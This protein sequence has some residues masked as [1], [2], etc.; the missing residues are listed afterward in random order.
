MPSASTS[1]ATVAL[2]HGSSVGEAV[3]VAVGDTVG[4]EVGK[5]VGGSVGLAV[6]VAVGVAVGGTVGLEVGNAVGP[7]VGPAV[8]EAV[9]L[10]VGDPVGDA[11]GAS[12]GFWKPSRSVAVPPAETFKVVGSPPDVC[13]T[14]VGRVLS[15][16]SVTAGPAGTVTVYMPVES[17]VTVCDVPE[18]SVM[19]TCTLGS[20]GSP[21][22]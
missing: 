9:G 22:S 18:L 12:V 13:T 5:E 2:T 7:A 6:G 19:I 10:A 15:T 17:V 20:P 21:W 1:K 4:D 11:V 8:G 16:I 14:P 3:G